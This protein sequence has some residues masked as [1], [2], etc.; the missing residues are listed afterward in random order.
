LDRH[1]F[2]SRVE[3]VP[4]EVDN[5]IAPLVTAAAMANGD[6]PRIVTTTFFAQGGSQRPLRRG[7]GDFFK[8]VA[9]HS[10]AACR[11]GLVNFYRH[12]LYLPSRLNSSISWSA[13]SVTMA[14]FHWRERTYQRRPRLPR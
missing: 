10:P 14:F 6:A 2:G 7:F 4:L 11:G 9:R 13:G 1:H 3:L 8:T 12:N 5:T